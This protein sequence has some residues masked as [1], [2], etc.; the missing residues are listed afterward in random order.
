MITAGTA[1]AAMIKPIAPAS[2]CD[3]CTQRG[4]GRVQC[5]ATPTLNAT[6]GACKE[7]NK[8]TTQHHPPHEPRQQQIAQADAALGHNCG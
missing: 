7:R 1:N 5:T 8:Y 3:K 6:R 2:N 4:L